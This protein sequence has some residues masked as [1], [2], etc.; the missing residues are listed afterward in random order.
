[1]AATVV[2]LIFFAATCSSLLLTRTTSGKRQTATRRPHTDH[3]YCTRRAQHSSRTQQ[4][5]PVRCRCRQAKE[6]T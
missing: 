3:S 5:L 1:M 4:R 2:S 6:C